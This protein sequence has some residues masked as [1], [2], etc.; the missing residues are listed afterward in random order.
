M[1]FKLNL[2]GLLFSY[3]KVAM[4]SLVIMLAVTGLNLISP[5]IMKTLVDEAIPTR[6]LELFFLCLSGIVLIPVVTT[7]FSSVEAYYAEDLASRISVLL[8]EQ[9]IE[10][11]LRLSPKTV[12]QYKQGELAD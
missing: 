10:K 11:L 2:L 8:R 4:F 1:K 9:L 7:I 5:L 3:K 12:Y 6:D